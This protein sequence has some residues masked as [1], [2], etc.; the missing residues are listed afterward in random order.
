M[1]SI[2]NDT[3]KLLGICVDDASFDTDIIVLINA[4]L[5]TLNQIGVGV[6]GFYII[7]STET[8]EQF[9]PE[10][11]KMEIVKAYVYQKVKLDFD[12]P[13]NTTVLQALNRQIAEK[14]WRL[15]ISSYE[16]ITS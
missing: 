11:F 3:K 8:W 16:P 12:P 13:A 14:E 2:L 1:N 15:S 6:D 4:T 7:D 10:P 5:F 9:I